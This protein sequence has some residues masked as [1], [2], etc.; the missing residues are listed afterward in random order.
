MKGLLA[1]DYAL[2]KQ[3]GKILIFLVLWGIIMYAV[4]DD[5]FF[6]VG[7]VVM[8]AVITSLSTM[9]YD[10][11]DNSM[12]FLMSLP[13]TRKD[14][15]VEKYLFSALCGIAFWIISLII[16]IVGNTVTG[17]AVLQTE[18]LSGMLLF[19]AVMFLILAVCIPPQ[20]KW[21]AEKGRI[22]MLIIFGVVFVA[23]FLLGRF[24]G[25]L[26]RTAEWLDRL[27]M[28]G[29]VLGAL[30][31]SLVLTA[32]SVMFSILIMQKKEF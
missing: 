12:P 8:I 13:V 10:E 6:V 21:G 24:G 11:Y 30:A 3:R 28:P 4:M 1:K 15:A 31:A 26:K 17:K 20:L 27:S 18:D 22:V 32:I 19:L 9:S 2:M 29:V 5:G 23:A 16:V 14:Y 25:G 7:W